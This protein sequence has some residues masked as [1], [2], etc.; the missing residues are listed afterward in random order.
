[1]TYKEEAKQVIVQ[2][3]KDRKG[4]PMTVKSIADFVY[5]QVGRLV[6]TNDS[7]PMTRKLIRELINEGHCIGSNRDGYYL[8]FNGK[9]VQSYL[10]SLL[11]RQIAISK[12]IEAVYNAAKED[13]LL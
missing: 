7:Y 12:R 13:G 2:V 5:V 1:M 4:R 9:E 6:E 10:N 11:Q 3:L 8:M